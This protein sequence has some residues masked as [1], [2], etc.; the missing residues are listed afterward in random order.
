MQKNQK[1]K[2]IKKTA[3]SIFWPVQNDFLTILRKSFFFWFFSFF[4]S[5]MFKNHSKVMFLTQTDLG[6]VIFMKK[7]SR[8]IPEKP[9]F[10][11]RWP[12]LWLFLIFEDFCDFLFKT[13]G[14]YQGSW[15]R[16]WKH[17]RFLTS[18]RRFIVNLQRV[19]RGT[20]R[21]RQPDPIRVGGDSGCSFFESTT[22]TLTSNRC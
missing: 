16:W 9:I 3:I 14:F 12:I 21:G 5:K 17:N 2:K 1:N 7:P 19:P 20:P 18:R 10:D 22:R 11:P 6:N 13:I 8:L 15:L 4:F